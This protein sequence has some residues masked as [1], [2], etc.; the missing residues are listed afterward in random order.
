M[1]AYTMNKKMIPDRFSMPRI[2]E[3]VDM[4]RYTQPKVFT[5]LDLTRGYHLVK[6]SE[7][8][9]PRTAFTYLSF[10]ALPV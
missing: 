2:D 5:C 6:M 1:F 7:Y 4:V 9:K 3:L 10:R 8:L